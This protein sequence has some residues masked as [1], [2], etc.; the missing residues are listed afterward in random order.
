MSTA[1]RITNSDGVFT[2]SQDYFHPASGIASDSDHDLFDPSADKNRVDESME[3]LFA[4][5]RE[6]LIVS[7]IVADQHGSVTIAFG[8]DSSLEILPMDS[9]DRERWRFFSQLSEEKHLVVYRTHI[10]GA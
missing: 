8:G 6:D 1:W 10:E 2:G 3:L 4:N 9:I 7:S 5:G